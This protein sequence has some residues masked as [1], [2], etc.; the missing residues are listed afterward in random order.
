MQ[1]PKRIFTMPTTTNIISGH[2][3]LIR[4]TFQS[5]ENELKW[6][7]CYG[8]IDTGASHCQ[9]DMHFVKTIRCKQ[10]LQK[11]INILA[12]S[13]T[14][15]ETDAYEID[16]NILDDD[17]R[18]LNVLNNIHSNSMDFTGK[19]YKLIIGRNALQHFLYIYDGRNNRMSLEWK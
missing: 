11:G 13:S 19:P 4:F 3:P 18:Y 1:L 8:L 5:I 17:S 14:A 10:L 9:I 7:E 15:K 16:L 2:G 6:V 12:D